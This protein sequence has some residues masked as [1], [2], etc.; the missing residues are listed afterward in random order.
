MLFLSWAGGRCLSHF[1]FWPFKEGRKWMEGWPV[2][3]QSCLRA[4]AQWEL[5]W[6]ENMAKSPFCAQELWGFA[7]CKG[8]GG[9]L[10]ASLHKEFHHP[11]EVWFPF[12]PEPPDSR[13]IILRSWS[14]GIE[15]V[16]TGYHA[17]SCSSYL[18]VVSIENQPN[19]CE[20]TKL[21][22]L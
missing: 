12:L 14:P 8:P 19:Q 10:V 2:P 22:N 9:T 7:S 21:L 11:G 18:Y 3:T 16:T 13:G 4:P 5:L 20:T 15:L 6:R 1:L 17:F